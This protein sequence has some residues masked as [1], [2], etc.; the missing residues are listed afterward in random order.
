MKKKQLVATIR[1]AMRLTFVYAAVSVIF[2]YSVFANSLAAQGI[3]D[4]SVSLSVENVTLQKVIS[5]VQKQTGVKFIYSPDAINASQ[6]VSFITKDKKLVTFIEESLKPLG[7]SYKV[8][9]NQI[10]LFQTSTNNFIGSLLD[11]TAQKVVSGTVQDENGLGLPGATVLIKGTS[12]SAVTNSNGAFA[13]EITNDDAILVVSF[14]GYQKQEVAVNGR[15][16]INIKLLPSEALLKDVVVVGYG[17]QKKSDVTGSVVRANIDQVRQA[18][19]A[20]VGQMLQGTVAGLNIGQVSVAGQSPS[21]QLRGQS[22]ISGNQ[23]VL[24][25]LDGIVYSGSLSSINPSDITSIDVLKDASSKAI[26]GASAANGVLLITTKKG[27]VG[28]KPVINVTSSYASQNPAHELHPLNREEFLQKIR[29]LNWKTAYLA[30]DYVAPNPTFDVRS[31][32]D[33]TQREN[34]DNGTDYSWYDAATNPGYLTDQQISVSNATEKANY[35]ISGGY[36]KQ[37]GFITQDQFSRISA[38]VNLESKVFNWLTLGVQSFAAFADYSGES[39]SLHDLWL[40]SPLNTPYDSNGEIILTPNKSFNNPFLSLAANSY[41]KRNSLFGNFYTAMDIPYIKGLNYRLNYGNNYYWNNYNYSNKYSANFT[42]GANKNNDDT[43]DY[44]FDNILNYK[45]NFNEAHDIDFTFVYGVRER[46]FSYTSGA[47]TGF[48]NFSLGYNSLE[49]STIQKIYSDAWSEAYNYQMARLNYGYKSKYLLTATLRRDGFSGF[50]E[51]KKTG[52]FPSFAAAWNLD[53]EPFFKVS[54]V[55]NLKLRLGYGSNGNLV[56]RYSSLSSISQGASYVFG[57][58]AA[59]QF[60]QQMTSLANPDLSWESTVGMNAGID[61]SILKGRVSGSVDYYN[62][63][64]RDLLF[65]VQIPGITG[66]EQI[67][68]NVGKVNNTGIEFNINSTNVRA[69]DFKWNSVFNISSNKNKIKEL[70]GSGD[71]VSSNL[72]IGR[73][74]GAI[75]NYQTNGLWQIGETP[76]A[77]YAVGSNKLVDVNNDE[78]ISSDDRVFLGRTEPA[79]RFSIGNTFSFKQFSLFAFINSVQGGKNGY[80]GFNN[81]WSDGGIQQG[82]NAIRNNWFRE[83]DYWT[84]AN[85]N[86]EYRITGSVPA[87]DPGIY[88]DRSFVRLQDVSLSYDI[89]QSI[90]SKM[91]LKGCR[92]Y[93]SGKNLATWTKW[94]GWDPESLQN[95]GYSGLTYIAG[96][97]MKSYSLGLNVTF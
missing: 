38:R 20:T 23:D 14:I 4:K 93:V 6:K 13:L 49:Q 40:Y 72:F 21:I 45:R 8:V 22:T 94:K 54:W 55:N 89:S 64:T 28:A 35:Y 51:N 31:K 33:P 16:Q 12:I 19:N 41:D 61:L 32:L 39:P 24:I 44:T 43:Y 82:D 90:A 96:P 59:T 34:Y 53:R 7:I 63:D 66:F 56:R 2:T 85:P 95:G 97:I 60:G 84:P 81:P 10:L 71:L 67:T 83:V 65:N 88:K 26:Y 52:F 3:L 73:S 79:Y 92:V 36:T 30:P 37:K 46:E 76:P 15:T 68:M 91:G 57:D 25:I 47:G 86:A 42:G 75:Y 62:N 78:K 77:G 18:P 69:K 17:S 58:G 87:I 27:K 11:L 74:V 70:L 29:D 80:L 50:A 5:H 9:D 1:F 48:N